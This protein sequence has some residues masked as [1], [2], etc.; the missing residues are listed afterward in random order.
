MTLTAFN[1]RRIRAALQEASG[2]PL[3][4]ADFAKR[5]GHPVDA[6]E[7]GVDGPAA[8]MLRYLSQGLPGFRGDLA[9][10][11][12][13]RTLHHDAPDKVLCRLWWPRFVGE[14]SKPAFKPKTEITRV[15]WIDDPG[16]RRDN[17]P[18]PTNQRSQKLRT[19]FG[20]AFPERSGERW[21]LP[22]S[23]KT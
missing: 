5:Y 3:S 19:H 7:V 6:E 2:D 15:H 17:Q 10:W 12:F 13:Q 21:S 22:M 18:S 8:T 14:L 16:E 9:E 4:A 11:S 20:F 23:K 1:V